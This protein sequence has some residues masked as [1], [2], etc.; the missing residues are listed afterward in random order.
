M[1][2]LVI[3]ALIYATFAAANAQQ[4]HQ[5]LAA[6]F[7]PTTT[8]QMGI[9]AKNYFLRGAGNCSNTIVLNSDSTFLREIGCEGH[10][11]VTV[12]KWRKFKD[13]IELIAFEQKNISLICSVNST[14]NEADSTITF[15][16]RDKL[17]LPIKAFHLIETS[18]FIRDSVH[19]GR[20]NR[21]IETNLNSDKEG[22]IVIHKS[23]KFDSLNFYK[24][25]TITDKSFTVAF[26]RLPSKIYIQLNI[27]RLG[28]FYTD[29]KYF[30]F[31]QPITF[32]RTKNAL[33]TGDNIWR[34]IKFT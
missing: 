27:N 22:K 23:T 6:F 21:R 33:R 2:F 1:R 19:Y 25:K 28:L 18:R 14:N 17:G 31:S 30:Y 7:K 20:G 10:S 16:F 3:H 13:S 34:K 32:K 15:Y 26:A 11:F 12:G 8:P 4:S 5:N 29:L 24:F 9:S